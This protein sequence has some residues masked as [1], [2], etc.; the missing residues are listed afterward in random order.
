[1]HQYTF[2]PQTNDNIELDDP[3]RG[4]IHNYLYKKGMETKEKIKSL[5]ELKDK[6]EKPKTEQKNPIS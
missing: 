4:D 6:Y 2:K 3:E 5:S 1:M